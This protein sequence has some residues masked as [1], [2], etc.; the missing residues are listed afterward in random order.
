MFESVFLDYVNNFDLNDKRVLLKLDHSKRV[1]DLSLK[2]ARILNY[3]EADIKLAEFI[4]LYH[5]IGR[6]NQIK[7]YQ[8]FNDS[9]SIDHGLEGIRVLFDEGLIDKFNFDDYEKEIIKFAIKNHN[10]F[11]IEETDDERKLMHAKLI[12]DTDKTD[13]VYIFGTL[14]K[15]WIK[16]EDEKFDKSVIEIFKNHELMPYMKIKNFEAIK[17]FGFAF[18]INNVEIIKEFKEYLTEFYK[19]LNREDLFKEIY[20]EAIKYLEGREKLC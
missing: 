8:T 15:D 16:V 20:D 3:N 5:D 10:Q 2:Y 18:E 13:I 9:I 7:E 4:G 11:E 14:K 6:F 19:T 17:Y 12:R 1:R